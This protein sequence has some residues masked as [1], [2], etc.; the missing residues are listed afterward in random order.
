MSSS[1]GYGPSASGAQERLPTVIPMFDGRL[2][3]FEDFRYKVKACFLELGLEDMTFKSHSDVVAARDKLVK[4]VE[5][6]AQT[7]QSEEAADKA[8]AQLVVFD[9]KVAKVARLLISHLLPSVTDR[10][11]KTLP[12]QQHFDGSS[13]WEYLQVTR[14]DPARWQSTWHQ[15][16]RR[17]F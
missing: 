8:K 4:A 10:L 9:S 14:M 3:H 2:E 12:E 1:T 6:K 5:S 11:R 13:I 15:T 16:R 17:L 7:R